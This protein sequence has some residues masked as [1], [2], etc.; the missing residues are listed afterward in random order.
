V[1]ARGD[2]FFTLQVGGRE[3]VVTVDCLKQNESY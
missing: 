1:L 2:K 3:D